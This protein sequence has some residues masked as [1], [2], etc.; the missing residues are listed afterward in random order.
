MMELMKK[1]CKYIND[2]KIDNHLKINIAKT[3]GEIGRAIIN[4][5]LNS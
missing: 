2:F 5:L 3:V 4:K 1:M